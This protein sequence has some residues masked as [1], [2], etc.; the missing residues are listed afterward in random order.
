MPPQPQKFRIVDALGTNYGVVWN[1]TEAWMLLR[2]VEWASGMRYR[3]VDN[4]D[5]ELT[6]HDKMFSKKIVF[7]LIEV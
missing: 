2:G 1:M 7:K 4:T 5:R 3:Y 6:L